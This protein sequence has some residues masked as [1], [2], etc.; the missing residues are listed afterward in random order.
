M[1]K[2]KSAKLRTLIALHTLYKYTDKEHR[3][4]SLQLNE[5]LRP[6]G[7]ECSNIFLS[8][9]IRA[10]QEYGIDVYQSGSF[11][12]RGVFVQDHPLSEEQLQK[13][14]FAVT[15][16]PHLSKDQATE[17]LQGLKPFVTVY[18]E[19]LLRGTVETDPIM[20]SEDLYQTYTIIQEAISSDRRI[21]FRV[22]RLKYDKLNQTVEKVQRIKMRF[23]PRYLFQKKGKLYMVGYNSTKQLFE[24]VDLKDIT[25][26]SPAMQHTDPFEAHID[27]FFSTS[28][29]RELIPESKQTVIYEGNATFQC[30]GLYDMD[31]F[32]RFGAPAAPVIR[33]DRCR[34]TYHV[35]YASITTDDLNWL[36]QIPGY[37]V[38]IVGPEPLVEAARI[39]YTSAVSGLLDPVVPREYR[40][41]YLG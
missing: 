24:A 34:V 15:T 30:Y 14:I 20:V 17:I 33:D 27:Q 6:Y 16:N 22:D 29:S 4:N 11:E 35:P 39:Y 12:K 23:T 38:R 37:G 13:L 8:K 5:Y 41:L 3:M 2:P 10:M 9:L 21:V 26:I 36:S 31:L 18:Q 25:Y 40:K 19:P 32:R 1:A 28:D 7:L